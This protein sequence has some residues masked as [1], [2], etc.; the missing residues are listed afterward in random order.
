MA[1]DC[2]LAMSML[3]HF[4]ELPLAPDRRRAARRALRLGAGT[5]GEPVTIL[6]LSLTGALLECPVPMLVGA[7]FEIDLPHVGPVE[8]EIVWSSGEYYGCQF[9]LPVSPAAVS[10]ALLQGDAHPPTDAAHDP[11]AELKQLNAEVEQL[12]LKMDGALR[13]LTRN[14]G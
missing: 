9:T 11:I 5:D 10:A 13:R 4:E 2:C 3:A 1:P 14:Q 7:R 6:D 8:A 12:A